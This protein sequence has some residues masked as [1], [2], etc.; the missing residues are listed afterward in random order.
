[1]GGLSPSYSYILA[2]V[3]LEQINK[4]N[5]FQISVIFKLVSKFP[6]DDAFFHG[7]C[8]IVA[9]TALCRFLSAQWIETELL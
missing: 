7:P 9:T 3:E 8:P 5:Y 6:P 1:M 2:Y 4:K